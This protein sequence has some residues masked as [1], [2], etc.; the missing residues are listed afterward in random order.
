[1]ETWLL[2]MDLS[3]SRVGDAV[4]LHA[5]HAVPSFWDCC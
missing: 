3:H 1:M 5:G 2:V 4:V